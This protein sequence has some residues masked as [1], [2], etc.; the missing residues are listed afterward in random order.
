MLLTFLSPDARE[1]SIFINPRVVMVSDGAGSRPSHFMIIP[2]AKSHP[3][4]TKTDQLP[5]SE[6]IT[7]LPRVYHTSHLKYIGALWSPKFRAKKKEKYPPFTS[8]KGLILIE[9]VCKNSVSF[10]NGGDFW[11]LCGKHVQFA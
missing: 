6:V 3:N 10:K 5:I 11:S 8:R 4:N 1:K 7:G 2:N 9:H